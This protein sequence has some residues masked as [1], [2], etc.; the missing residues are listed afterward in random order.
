MQTVL[1]NE[2]LIAHK[3]VEESQSRAYDSVPSAQP[4]R[5]VSSG[6]AFVSSLDFERIV[7]QY[8]IQAVRDQWLL[9]ALPVDGSV[10]SSTSQR[11]DLQLSS[12]KKRRLSI[13]GYRMKPK[14]TGHLLG[15]T[16]RTATRWILSA[17]AGLLT[18]LISNVIVS[19]FGNC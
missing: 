16:G 3:G 1:E 13:E 15:Y 10:T 18:G 8:S 4:R 9:P 11:I 19:V 17:L 2:P 7:N 12:N 6:G 14:H 5:R